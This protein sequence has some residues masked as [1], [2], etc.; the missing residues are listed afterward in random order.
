MQS[1][2]TMSATVPW[3]ASRRVLYH[4]LELGQVETYLVNAEHAARS[5]QGLM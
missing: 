2:G 1:S 3:N 4:L 5:D